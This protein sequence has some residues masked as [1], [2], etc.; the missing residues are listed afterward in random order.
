M[1]SNEGAGSNLNLRKNI[2]YDAYLE[3]CNSVVKS[4]TGQQRKQ[5]NIIIFKLKVTLK[6]V[7][8]VITYCSL[9]QVL[10]LQM[11]SVHH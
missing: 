11:K 8:A 3:I 10:M 2:L 1:A 7:L 4:K 9:S 5:K 6:V